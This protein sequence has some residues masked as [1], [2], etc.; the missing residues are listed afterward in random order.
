MINRKVLDLSHYNDITS[1]QAIKDA[2]IVGIIHKATE[3]TTNIDPKYAERVAR[4]KSVGLL[5]GAYH[6]ATSAPVSTQVD[7]FLSVVGI[8]DDFLYSLDWEDAPNRTMTYSQ[9]KEFIQRIDDKIG[10]NRCVVYGGNTVK[11]RVK[12]N[13]AFFGSHRLWL[14]QYGTKPTWQQ[15]WDNYWLWQYTDGVVGPLPHSCPGV[16][17]EVDSNSFDGTDQQLIDQWSGSS[18]PV[19]TPITKVT[20]E[21]KGVKPEDVKVQ[22]NAL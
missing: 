1:Y 6:Y 10:S 22:I 4:A 14:C 12:G 8:H 15:S 2:G 16:T 21:I 9:A 11:E 13:D 3:S 20:I 7:H 5:W 19:P 17:G 18:V